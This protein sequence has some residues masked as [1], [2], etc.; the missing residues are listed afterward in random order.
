MS[1]IVLPQNT[2]TISE[3]SYTLRPKNSYNHLPAYYQTLL[4]LMNN[5][6]LLIVTAHL[7]SLSATTNPLINLLHSTTTQYDPLVSYY[8]H[9]LLP[10]LLLLEPSVALYYLIPLL[11]TSLLSL[12][13]TIIAIYYHH[14]CTHFNSLPATNTSLTPTLTGSYHTYLCTA[15][16]HHAMQ[17]LSYPP[18]H[19][20][21][22]HSLT[23][24]AIDNCHLLIY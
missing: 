9:P 4:W 1:F 11:F 10:L 20:A 16:L 3:L 14:L 24:F 12:Q 7:L 21:I 8:Y 23:L 2:N 19:I 18:P 15:T 17:T 5:C 22:V 13:F 6:N